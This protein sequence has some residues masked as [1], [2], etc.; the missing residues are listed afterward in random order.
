MIHRR[1]FLVAPEQNSYSFFSG[2]QVPVSAQD[3]EFCRSKLSLFEG[4]IDEKIQNFRRDE[5]CQENVD[6]QI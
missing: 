6:S 4:N 3:Y 1:N 2:S 5:K